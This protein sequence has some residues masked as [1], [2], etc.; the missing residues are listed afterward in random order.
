MATRRSAKKSPEVPHF[1]DPGTTRQLRHPDGRNYSL[2]V[3]GCRVYESWTLASGKGQANRATRDDAPSAHAHALQKLRGLVKKGYVEGAPVVRHRYDRD[4]DVVDTFHT[5]LDYAG[6]RRSDFQPVAGRPQVYSFSNISVAEWLV[7]RDDRKRG[8]RFRA[9]LFNSAMDPAVRQAYADRILSE[10]STR[11][12]EI[13]DDEATPLRKL[14]LADPIGRFTHLV[15]LSPEVANVS[16]SR[17]VNIAN[18]ILGRSVFVAFPAFV[19]E[20]VGDETVA[21]AEARTAGR[22]AIPMAAWDRDPHPVVDLAYPKKP[23]ETPNFLVYDP[24]DV[25]RR[26]GAKAWS[27]LG[28]SALHAR[29]H[30]REVRVFTGD[31]PAPDIADVRAFFGFDC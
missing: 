28:S 24:D 27:K 15:V 26:F 6:K 25:E 30:A 23:S 20:A 2:E 8:V 19:S 5:D 21:V 12:S 22:G 3:D 1:A 16:I 4:A 10:L 14:P 13:F 7:T 11:R 9:G 29:N 17:D 18:P 31:S